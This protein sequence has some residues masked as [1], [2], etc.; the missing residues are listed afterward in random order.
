VTVPVRVQRILGLG[1][2]LLPAGDRELT[3]LITDGEARRRLED[4]MQFG[5]GALESVDEAAVPRT[6][7]GRL[8][9][10][11]QFAHADALEAG[12][13]LR[14]SFLPTRAPTRCCD[15]TIWSSWP[16]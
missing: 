16:E 3:P 7:L 13:V 4:E 8:G 1:A 15:R 12:S 10:L 6:L 11:R 2:S 5:G 14:T 9:R